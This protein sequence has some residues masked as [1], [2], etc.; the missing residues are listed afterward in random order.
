[1]PAVQTTRIHYTDP[2]PEEPNISIGKKTERSLAVYPHPENVARLR[3]LLDMYRFDIEII[4]EQVAHENMRIL[5]MAALFS[6]LLPSEDHFKADIRDL[7]SK[8]RDLYGQ[9]TRGV[10]RALRERAE[11]LQAMLF[12]VNRPQLFQEKMEAFIS[13][14]LIA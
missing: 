12:V 7:M 4:Q 14:F 9:W 10:V 6:D 3:R 13:R 11:A 2:D 8:R 5:A 1:M